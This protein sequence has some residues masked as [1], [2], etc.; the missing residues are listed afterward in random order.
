VTV[1][2]E[3]MVRTHCPVPEQGPLVQPEKIDPV[4]AVAFSVAVDP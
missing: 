4:P 1:V 3:F 2:F